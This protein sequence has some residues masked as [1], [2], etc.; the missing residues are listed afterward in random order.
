M[1][2]IPLK[3]VPVDD[4][5]LAY[6]E[7][8]SGYPVVFINGLASTMDMWNPPV[9][10][11]ISEY[12][13]VIIFDSR[14]TGYSSASDKPFS[15][16]LLAHDTAILMDAL[17]ISSAHILGLSMGAS[18]AQELALSFPGKVNKLILVAGE[19]GGS[20]SVKAQAEIMSQLMDKS[21]TMHDVVNRMFFLLFPSSWLAVHD[22]FCYCPDVYETTGD[23]IV[24]R[25]ASAFSEWTGSFFRLAD[26]CSPT[27]VITGTDDV[28]I[29][30]VNSHIISGRIPGAQLVEIPG[31][32]HGLMYQFPDRFSDCVLT[33]LNR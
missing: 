11:K 9:I 18:V 28:I 20:E 29:P 6:S 7:S 13:R 4:V 3:T 24:A 33:F 5:S 14:G 21:G 10:A 1:T 22:P 25:Q 30:P 32:G 8:G 27:L 17:G 16:P 2:P 12:F 23:E 19:C 31:A 26:I 15:I